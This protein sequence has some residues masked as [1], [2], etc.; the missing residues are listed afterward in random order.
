MLGLLM[1]ATVGCSAV[2]APSE[3]LGPLG[4]TQTPGSA[5]T[6][7]ARAW[8]A[9]DE[10]AAADLADPQDAS[11]RE[12]LAIPA[13]NVR[14]LG[15]RDVALAPSSPGLARVSWRVSSGDSGPSHVDVR[16]RISERGL[17]IEPS[18]TS[19]TPLWLIEPRLEAKGAGPVTVLGA[20]DHD[21]VRILGDARRARRDVRRAWPTWDG[22]L[23]VEVASSQQQMATA[24]GLPTAAYDGIAAVTSS[25]DGTS[26]NTTPV[27]VFVNPLV[28]AGMSAPAARVVMTHEVVHVAT[29]AP[30]I[31]VPLWWA[32]GVAEYL[33]FAAVASPVARALSSAPTED[34]LAQV[35]RQGPP[36]RL[37]GPA[38]F[39]GGERDAAYAS[40]RVAVTVLADL[41][42]RSSGNSS[43]ALTRFQAKLAAGT[44]VGAALR[45]VFGINRDDFVRRWRAELVRLTRGR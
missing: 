43:H 11:A 36:R 2:P 9:G 20:P 1:V 21:L 28:Y 4:S 34:L 29:R 41:G 23:V 31:P 7:V 5:L 19:P 27:H 37:P 16:I 15:L 30:V 32:E 44:D 10:A 25:S 22:R 39:G 3:A 38:A 13:R 42:G 12:L 24:L 40:A 33:G 45:S 26:G 6:R 8:A 17:A 35:A 14:A 18:T